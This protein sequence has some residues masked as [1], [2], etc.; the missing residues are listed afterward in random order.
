MLAAILASQKMSGH[1]GKGVISKVLHWL[2]E[3]SS[4]ERV[5]ITALSA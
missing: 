4:K 1:D 3:D 2:L 5:I